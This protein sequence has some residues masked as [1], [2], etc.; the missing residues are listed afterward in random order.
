[1]KIHEG[2]SG[3]VSLADVEYEILREGGFRMSAC[4]IHKLNMVVP[5]EQ[6]N[7]EEDEAGGRGWTWKESKGGGWARRI[8]LASEILLLTE[9]PTGRVVLPAEEL[10]VHEEDLTE[11]QIEMKEKVQQEPGT[12]LDPSSEK[13]GP[14]KDPVG[15][16]R[17]RN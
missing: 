15:V 5:D 11:V 1:M 7:M 3:K 14:H 13:W 2:I 12:R 6:Q 17:R 9:E 16:W 4:S 10:T 8:S